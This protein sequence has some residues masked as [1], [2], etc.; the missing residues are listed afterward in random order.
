MTTAYITHPRYVE[1]DIP[2]H[3]EHAGRIRAVWQALDEAG[4]T[5]RMQA[6]LPVEASDE[7]ILSVHTESYL[8]ILR[9]IESG[10]RAVR[11]D[12]DTIALPQTPAVARL[13]AGG[14]IQA[15]DAVL[16]GAA[17]NALA[18]VRPPGHHAIPERAMGFCYLGNVAIAARHA[19]RAHGLER[20][21]IV[22]YDVHHGNGTQDA[23]YDDGSV[24]FF[25]THQ[26]PYYPGTG[27]MDE[28]G[29]GRGR[30]YTVNVPLNAG[31]G[32]EAY[33]RIYDDILWPLARRFRPQLM[34][35][36]AGFDAHWDDP[37]AMMRLSLTGFSHLDREL[38]RMADELCD[39]RIVY[40]LEGGY[41][42]KVLA[43]GV[44]NI[45]RALLGDDAIHDPFGPANSDQRLTGDLLS[46]LKTLHRL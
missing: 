6:I 46:R 22:D 11:F 36:S 10:E 8:D 25:S 12:M 30:G 23:L 13:A 4:L 45:A 24:L 39:G 34:L 31:C 35:V 28:T 27:S 5:G 3:P 2:G 15:V 9:Q 29:S 37:L 7:H 41:N 42:L 26:Y 32:D 43:H 21:L 14:V 18:A 16:S 40:V 19:Q 33:A 1:H 20:V 17:D 44:A 38:M